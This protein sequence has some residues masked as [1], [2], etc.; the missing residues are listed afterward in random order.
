MTLGI[1]NNKNKFIRKTIS[2]FITL[3]FSCNIAL[4]AY[5]QS[6][7]A[8]N[9]I[10]L[11]TTFTPAVIKGLRVSV[12]NPLKFNFI[13]DRGGFEGAELK[14]EYTKLIK[15]FL[16]SLT[17]KEDDMWVNLNPREQNRIIPQSFGQ[18]EMGRDLLSQDYLLKQITSSLMHPEG[19]VGKKFWDEIYAQTYQ[20]YGTTDVDVDTLNKVW[21]VPN[22]SVVY[23]NEGKAFI[24]EAN[25]KVM[26]EEEYL[27]SRQYTVG[28]RQQKSLPTA[29]SQLP[30]QIIKNIIIPK[31][32]Q[33]VNNGEYFAPLR[34]I[35]HSLILAVWY[36][37]KLKNGILSKLYVDKGKIAGVDIEDK[38][39]FKKIYNKY[40]ETFKKGAYSYIKEEYDPTTQSIIPKKYF[41]GG[42]TLKPNLEIVDYMDPALL[43]DKKNIDDVEVDLAMLGKDKGDIEKLKKSLN[44]IKDEVKV[45][46]FEDMGIF[47]HDIM[48]EIFPLQMVE[49]FLGTALVNISESEDIHAQISDLRNSLDKIIN[50]TNDVQTAVFEAL[51]QYSVTDEDIDN[52]RLG[53][54]LKNFKNDM[55]NKLIE[56]TQGAINEKTL[57]AEEARERMQELFDRN[58]SLFDSV[59]KILDK[60][61]KNSKIR[62]DIDLY[63]FTFLFDFLRKGLKEKVES[64]FFDLNSIVSYALRIASNKFHSPANIEVIVDYPK[65]LSDINADKVQIYKVLL[66]MLYNAYE[67]LEEHKELKG[68]I[69]I[70]VEEDRNENIVIKIIDSGRG[71]PKKI[72]KKVLKD[73]GATTKKGGSG[74][75]VFGS[76]QKIIKGLGKFNIKS[77][78]E[79]KNKAGN[80]TVIITIPKDYEKRAAEYKRRLFSVDK[81]RS[82]LRVAEGWLVNFKGNKFIP[83]MF[84]K[85]QKSIF[86][87]RQV[88]KTE[89]LSVDKIKLS[90]EEFGKLFNNL[91]E[92]LVDSEGEVEDIKEIIELNYEI[93]TEEAG[94]SDVE[95]NILFDLFIS[96]LKSIG[97]AIRRG[98]DEKHLDANIV[99]VKEIQEY[100]GLTLS[101]N[102][103]VLKQD[104]AMIVNQENEQGAIKAADVFKLFNDVQK[105]FASV[106]FLDKVVKEIV[107]END[108]FVKEAQEISNKLKEFISSYS[109]ILLDHNLNI[110]NDYAEKNS[111]TFLDDEAL[112]LVVPKL[113]RERISF[114]IFAYNDYATHAIATIKDRIENFNGFEEAIKDTA[115]NKFDTKFEIEDIAKFLPLLEKGLS[116]SLPLDDKAMIA[117]Q[118]NEKRVGGIDLTKDR[119]DLDIKS[120]NSF[121]FDIDLNGVKEADINGFMP[122]II[123]ILPINNL[124]LFLGLSKKDKTTS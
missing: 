69:K 2:V 124:P 43:V 70:S 76:K 68:I 60:H 42:A 115:K 122:V 119:L 120:E 77:I 82:I 96:F 12:D 34:Q 87:K 123:H 45:Q 33:E 85:R 11:G 54:S 36:K 28:N 50:I 51:E 95:E 81:I 74:I 88:I 18:T 9:P 73:Y 101:E 10:V 26:L 106:E 79:T 71:M 99:A 6:A 55:R 5:A 25:L 64:S 97:D 100:L 40:V 117:K 52:I 1:I 47:I 86:A 57:I 7:F 29:N 27:D 31:L 15:Y 38:Q 91:N 104:K 107:K 19:E 35:Y 13:V 98:I 4:P 111:M 16:A 17:T 61:I 114:N 93:I 92:A 78:E 105:E 48:K 24:V 21:I 84:A 118:V 23:E 121:D 41:S 59:F 112:E 3:A 62:E 89:V 20:K 72:R 32:E 113:T 80:T 65:N 14:G 39:E 83:T 30:T 103:N 22:K 49:I 8:N 44:K 116:G 110:L 90:L 53:G 46:I 108:N 37:Q 75:G 63:H 102:D 94:N 56:L 58:Q 66:N 67:E 109:E